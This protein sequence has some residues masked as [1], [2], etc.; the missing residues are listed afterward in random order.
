MYYY[1]LS[2]TGIMANEP[3]PRPPETVLNDKESPESKI[4]PPPTTNFMNNNNNDKNNK[5]N[6]NSSEEKK[7]QAKISKMTF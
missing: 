3:A 4:I 5:G 6:D 1:A 2:T 7:K